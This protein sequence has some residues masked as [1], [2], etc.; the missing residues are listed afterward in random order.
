MHLREGRLDD[1]PAQ[2]DTRGRALLHG[3][4]GVPEEVRLRERRDQRLSAGDGGS[5]RGLPRAL[6]RAVVL[7][8]GAPRVRGRVR[9]GPEQKYGGGRGCSGPADRRPHPA[10]RAPRGPGLLHCQRE[11]GQEGHRAGAERALSLRARLGAEDSGVRPR[12]LGPE[13]AQVQEELRS[14][15]QPAPVERGHA[16]QEECRGGAGLL[17][18][19]GDLGDAQ[20]G[21][22]ERPVLVRE[23]PGD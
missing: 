8:G 17:Q 1:P 12:R 18:E 4:E 2:G 16:Q 19:R 7:Q 11:A 5:Q 6:L 14:P 3:D 13:E 23:G 9:M 21:R 15:E 10:L 22:D 20:G